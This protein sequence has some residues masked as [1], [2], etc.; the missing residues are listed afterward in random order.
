MKNLF[1]AALLMVGM[2]SFA[3]EKTAPL[4]KREQTEKMTPEQRNELKL[5]RMT[6]ELGL[7][8]KQ[9]KEMSVLISEQT[10][11]RDAT[12]KERVANKVNGVKPTADEQFKKES[13]MLD[14][15]KDM[16]DKM[17]KILTPEQYAKWDKMNS[18]RKGKMKNAMEKSEK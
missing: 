16:L 6:V 2:A 7:N 13:Q 8:E 15:K 9:Q 3:Q 1:M 5:K 17:K 10:E 14:E 12:H 4:Q 18:E 11:K